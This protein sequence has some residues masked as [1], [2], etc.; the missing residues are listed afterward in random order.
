MRILDMFFLLLDIYLSL[1]VSSSFE[2]D[3]AAHIGADC[4]SLH[5][6]IG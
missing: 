2:K 1:L 3:Y 5:L 6:D 4:Y